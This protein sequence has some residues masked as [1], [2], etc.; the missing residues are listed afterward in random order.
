M[1]LSDANVRCKKC[2]FSFKISPKY[3]NE[4]VLSLNSLKMKLL[5]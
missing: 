2:R 1:Q 5:L 4:A 3:S